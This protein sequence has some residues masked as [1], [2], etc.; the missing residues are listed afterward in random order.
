M[1]ITSPFQFQM[2]VEER[3]TSTSRP[4]NLPRLAPSGVAIQKPPI[5]NDT[6]L[7]CMRK[8]YD[9]AWGKCTVEEVMTTFDENQVRGEIFRLVFFISL[10]HI[11]LFKK[12]ER[13]KI[14]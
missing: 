13:G 2:I 1:S 12:K 5:T 9:Q 6:E 10:F 14:R 4:L 3:R 8:S 11:Q 7:W